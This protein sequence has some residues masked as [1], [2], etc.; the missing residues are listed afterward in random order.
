MNIASFVLGLISLIGGGFV[1][2]PIL[3]II[4]GIVGLSKKAKNS[5]L[6][7][8]GI[9]L[10]ALGLIEFIIIIALSLARI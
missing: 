10:S 5:G 7:I 3:G 9:I 6:G 2:L 8:A 1:I 4:F